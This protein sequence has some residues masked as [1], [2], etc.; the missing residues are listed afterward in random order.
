MDAY[1]AD[2]QSSVNRIADFPSMG[3]P[4]LALR[5]KVRTFATGS[6]VIVYVG[7]DPIEV[8]RI[9]HQSSDWTTLLT[10]I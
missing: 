5:A 4:Q 6:H 1:L 2:I 7:E 8:V 9:V 10:N 3:R